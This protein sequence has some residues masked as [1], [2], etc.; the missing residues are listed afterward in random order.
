[1]ASGLRW[2]MGE[3]FGPWDA[4]LVTQLAQSIWPE[5]PP[6]GKERD[7]W[8]DELS[9]SYTTQSYHSNPELGDWLSA[10]PKR[11]N[12]TAI[13][14]NLSKR[15][16]VR[17]DTLSEI[18][19]GTKEHGDL[20]RVLVAH[21]CWSTD[22]SISM[23]YDG[24][25]HRGEWAGDRFDIVLPQNFDLDAESTDGPVWKDVTATVA[26]TM[27]DIWDSALGSD[28]RSSW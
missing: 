26:S 20:G 1:M 28:C 17:S 7:I 23:T 9:N 8:P 16:F 13:L 21:I 10:R 19:V 25:I 18:I 22:P 11:K 15:V 2:V 6:L 5:S 24:G 4:A 3:E 14:R 12:S 27:K